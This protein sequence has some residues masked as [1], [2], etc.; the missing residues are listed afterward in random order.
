MVPLRQAR[1]AACGSI[2]WGAWYSAT[3]TR[4]PYI[5]T[6]TAYSGMSASCQ[7]VA[8]DLLALQPGRQPLM[9]PLRIRLAKHGRP[10]DSSAGAPR[11]Q[12][13]QLPLSPADPAARAFIVDQVKQQQ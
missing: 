5:S 9:V 10:S 6:A 12:P 1:A 13:R 8:F 11:Q 7:P 3:H 4:C 2:P